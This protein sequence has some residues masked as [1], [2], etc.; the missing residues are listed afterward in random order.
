MA[1]LVQDNRLCR[2]ITVNSEQTIVNIRP[3]IKGAIIEAS[4]T[5][6]EAFISNKTLDES[7]KHID[8]TKRDQFL[9]NLFKSAINTASLQSRDFAIQVDGCK[10][11][12]IWSNQCHLFSWSQTIQY[13][14]YYNNNRRRLSFFSQLSSL[15]I[16]LNSGIRQKMK[17]PN[18]ST[19][20]VIGFIG[21][22]PHEQRNGVGTV[23]M[24]HVLEIADQ[25][26]Y[27][28]YVEANNTET[29]RF[30]KRFGFRELEQEDL[31]AHAVLT[32]ML[33]KP[34][35]KNDPKPLRIRPGRRDSDKSF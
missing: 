21:V 33:R 23:L 16:K 27:P 35:I 31:T 20:I 13:F 3:I 18:R 9:F 8:Y 34:V 15:F 19:V 1:L 29:I 2:Q 4:H 6:T 26:H 14:K 25:A 22:L 12:L 11:V 30:F 28:V 7:T 17:P 5:L 10:G 32:P 24:E